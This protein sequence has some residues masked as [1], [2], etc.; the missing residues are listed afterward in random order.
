VPKKI[1][2]REDCRASFERMI[3]VR[4]TD[5]PKLIRIRDRRGLLPKL[6]RVDER[7]EDE[8]ESLGLDKAVTQNDRIAITAGSRGITDIVTILRTSVDY[9]KGLGAKPF[10]VA[11][12]GS[13][14]GATASGQRAVLSSL[15][16]TQESMGCP[17][18]A[19]T[20][21]Q[22]VGKTSSGFPVHVNRCAAEADGIVVVNRVKP[23]T[24]FSG[25][26]GSGILKMISVGLGN[27]EGARL[28]HRLAFQHGFEKVIIEVALVSL[29]KLPI[30]GGIGIVENRLNDTA[31]IRGT[32]PKSFLEEDKNLLQSAIDFLPSLPTDEIDILIV[33]E[34]GKNISGSGMDTHIIGRS[35]V[36]GQSEPIRP[37]IKRIYVR[38]LTSES[39]GNAIGIGLA[40]FAH[41]RLIKKMDTYSTYLN[42]LTATGPEKAC[43]PPYFDKDKTVLK[44]CLESIGNPDP[45][46]VRL[47]WIKNTSEMEQLYVS[48][49]LLQEIETDTDLAVVSAPSDMAFRSDGNFDDR[50]YF[51]T[52]S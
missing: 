41:E 6:G 15:G 36:L 26:V 20:D 44:L 34:I 9:L 39:H 29:S 19:T 38:D 32:K 35:R 1:R 42:C 8:L 22:T 24:A 12:M 17:I 27:H 28:V 45:K 49:A 25:N 11:S 47:L 40:D 48:E 14:G 51:G 33:N 7:V 2:N 5:L 37:N 30:L 21:V 10:L 18:R 13:H 52:D 50:K 4:D 46:T 3:N 31:I 16:I 43:I 23:H